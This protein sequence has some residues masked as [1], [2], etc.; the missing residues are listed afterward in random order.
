MSRTAVAPKRKPSVKP[1]ELAVKPFPNE[2]YKLIDFLRQENDLKINSLRKDQKALEY[3][4]EERRAMEEKSQKSWREKERAATEILEKNGIEGIV[5]VSELESGIR[6]HPLFGPMPSKPKYSWDDPLLNVPEKNHAAHAEIE[7]NIK[8][9]R[10]RMND[11]EAFIWLQDEM[12]DEL[13]A[14]ITE[15]RA[16]LK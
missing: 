3:T 5:C 6:F 9:V 15:F 2:R 7:K 14:K 8:D 4:Y 11:L 1:I 12:T 16:S 13:K 10:Q